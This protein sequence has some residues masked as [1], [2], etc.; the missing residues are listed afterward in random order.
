MLRRRKTPQQRQVEDRLLRLKTAEWLAWQPYVRHFGMIHIAVMMT[1]VFSISLTAAQVP[2]LYF[3]H[4]FQVANYA[5]MAMLGAGLLMSLCFMLVIRGYPRGAWAL[6]GALVFCLACA[7]L[8]L[9]DSRQR[10]FPAFVLCIPLAG[11]YLMSTRRYQRGLKVL[12]VA[13]RK[14]RRLQRLEAGLKRVR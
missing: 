12:Q 4:D 11:L 14:R 10:L 2:H 6:F 7:L 8:V 13:A 3:P 9:L 5:A 1:T